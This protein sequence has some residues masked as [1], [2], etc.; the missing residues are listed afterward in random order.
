M[1]Y[2]IL[3]SR[4]GCLVFLVGA[5]FVFVCLFVSCG[6]LLEMAGCPLVDTQ[7]P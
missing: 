7:Q 2:S 1:I 6:M 4:S 5:L 3:S